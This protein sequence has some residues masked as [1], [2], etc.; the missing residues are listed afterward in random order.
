[1]YQLVSA[2]LTGVSQ[3]EG[4]A[5]VVSHPQQHF[6][7]AIAVQG[8]GAHQVGHEFVQLFLNSQPTTALELHQFTEDLEQRSQAAGVHLQ[9]AAQLLTEQTSVICTFNGFVY[10]RRENKIGLIL[11]VQE[12]VQIV[13]GKTHVDDVYVLGT[14]A[15]GVFDQSIQ[16]VLGAVRESDAFVTQ[17]MQSVLETSDSSLMAM[18][19][20]QIT[21]VRPTIESTVEG[22]STALPQEKKKL[23][24]LPL[25]SLKPVLSKL[26]T[27]FLMMGSGARQ[28][29]QPLFSRDVY[30]R[31]QST[32]KIVRVVVPVVVLLVIAFGVGLFFRSQQV[33]EVQAAQAVIQPAEDE[34]NQ[35][36]QIAETQPSEARQR[37]E[38][39]I[40][41]LEGELPQFEKQQ[42][43]RKEVQKELTKVK[44][45]YQTISGQQEVNVLPTFFDL[46]LF[47]SDFL[48]NRVDIQKNTIFFLDPDK[49]Q[50]L[51]L[52]SA[53]KQTTL[54][55]SGAL[56]SLKDFTVS[57]KNAYLLGGGISAFTLGTNTP[58]TLLKN[59]DL[60]TEP[61]TMIRSYG[62][63]IY[64]LNPEKRNIFRYIAG[65]DDKI[66]SPAAWL[67]PDEKFDV[68]VVQS[69]AIDGDVWLSTKTGEIKRFTS[70]RASTFAITGLKEPLS[71]PAKI[72]TKDGLQ[73][74]YI[75]EPEKNRFIVLNKTGEFIKE[76]RSSALAAASDLVAD[77]TSKTAYILSG[78]L[79]YDVKF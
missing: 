76:V 10:L 59:P 74:I 26:K 6:V 8:S 56:P 22:V 60:D 16:R 50:I 47:Q 34:L 48:A 29:V 62:D 2:P 53:S 51:A 69:M 79:V 31:R 68:S 77:E 36:K 33:K 71:T 30:V 19:Y 75:L 7:C 12:S 15:A 25:Q 28:T 49:K 54:L 39:L 64:L 70:G 3:P 1:M 46:R 20:V 44:E 4:W 66:S 27:L 21:P 65:D 73:N 13:E 14:A 78:S 52:D 67:K 42:T 11:P 61:A 23:T 40:A 5:Q 72:F 37:T 45:Y 55:P 32:K 9:F 35:I 17:V 18:A 57:D 58:P 63:Y 41:M 43:A 24:V 38:T